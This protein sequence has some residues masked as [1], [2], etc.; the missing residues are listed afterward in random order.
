MRLVFTVAYNDGR[1][2]AKAG[3]KVA[4]LPDHRIG[5]LIKAG[6]ISLVDPLDHDGDGQMGG[7]LKGDASTVAKGKRRRQ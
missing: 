4:G 5:V 7:S 1:I 3:D 2:V 6:V